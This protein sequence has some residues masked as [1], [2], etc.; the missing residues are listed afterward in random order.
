VPPM[1]SAPVGHRA[2][3]WRRV[4]RSGQRA[5]LPGAESYRGS[6]PLPRHQQGKR[7]LASGNAG[8]GPIS[9]V[10]PCQ[11]WPAVRE[12]P[13]E[14]AGKFPWDPGVIPPG[15]RGHGVA[16]ADRTH[17]RRPRRV[18]PVEQRQRLRP[19]GRR[20]Q[21]VSGRG[22]RHRF[23]RRRQPAP[24]DWPPSRQGNHVRRH[25]RLASQGGAGMRRGGA[26]ASRRRPGRIAGTAESPGRRAVPVRRATART[27]TGVAHTRSTSPTLLCSAAQA[28]YG[29][30]S[31]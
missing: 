24:Q 12:P 17:P 6:N 20:C 18:A 1:A 4:R 19:V 3:C 16:I 25:G 21:L 26:G 15:Q 22:C 11:L 14:Y 13:R 30:V 8:Q 29:S 27:A 28:R 7:P 5:R 31:A 2:G 9:S 23:R 10:Q